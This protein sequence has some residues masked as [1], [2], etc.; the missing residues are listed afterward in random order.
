MMTRMTSKLKTF[1]VPSQ[2]ESTYKRNDTYRWHALVVLVVIAWPA[3]FSEGQHST[4]PLLSGRALKICT[5]SSLHSTSL[6]NKYV[7]RLPVYL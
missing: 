3:K 6:S 2:I 4:I 5:L 7:E 1:V